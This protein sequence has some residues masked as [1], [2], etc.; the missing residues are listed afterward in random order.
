MNIRNPKWTGLAINGAVAVA[1]GAIFIFMPKEL[2]NSIV[3]ILGVVMGLAGI[4]M[5]FFTFFKQKS[6]GVLSTY[7]LIQGV[8][9]LALGAIMFLNPTL[10]VDFVMFVIGVWA[11]AIGVFQ[12]IFAINVRKIVNSGPFLLGNG[13]VFIGLG[14]MMILSPETVINTMLAILG[15][16]IGLLGFILLYFSYLIHKQNKLNNSISIQDTEVIT[17]EAE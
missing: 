9:N 1:I 11:V 5:L 4:A 10:M 8:V 17:K 3:K 2:I 15:S 7:Y 16:I 13:I 12:I 6:K 14:L